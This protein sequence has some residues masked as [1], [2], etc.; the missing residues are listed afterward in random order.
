MTTTTT[1]TL[2]LTSILMLA[3][4]TEATSTRLL[5]RLLQPA[6]SRAVARLEAEERRLEVTSL[7]QEG[8]S[9]VWS[10][11]PS[12]VGVLYLVAGEDRAGM[13][14]LVASSLQQPRLQLRPALL[15]RFQQV[16]VV[17]VTRGGLIHT[18]SITINTVETCGETEEEDDI[19]T[20]TEGE[21]TESEENIAST[22][23]TPEEEDTDSAKDSVA[24][25]EDEDIDRAEDNVAAP[26]DEDTDSAED[27][28]ATSALAWAAPHYWALLL[29]A[30][31]ALAVLLLA[32]LVRSCT[33][34]RGGKEGSQELVREAFLVEEV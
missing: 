9:L 4:T 11:A 19:Y 10:A 22:V 12:S 23:V 33:R 16:R 7:E 28:V 1:T 27:S 8:C 5:E 29:A 2:L 14:S 20:L 15:A 24:T 30:A 34:H 32:A 21:E 25:P 3:V 13:L 26:E 31:A 17:A 6:I 18:S